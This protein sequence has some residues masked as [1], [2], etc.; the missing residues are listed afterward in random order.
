MNMKVIN[1]IFYP[2]FFL[3][4]LAIVGLLKLSERKTYERWTKLTRNSKQE[5]SSG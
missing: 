5:E 3:L 4:V 2:F 1:W